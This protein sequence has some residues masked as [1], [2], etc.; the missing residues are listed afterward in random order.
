MSG[1]TKLDVAF[2]VC[3]LGIS[4]KCSDDEDIKYVNKIISHLKQEPVEITY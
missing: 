2:D 4:F 1:Q 3:Q